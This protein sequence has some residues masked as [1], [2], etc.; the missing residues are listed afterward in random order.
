MYFVYFVDIYFPIFLLYRDC[1]TEDEEDDL[2]FESLSLPLQTTSSSSKE[3]K[4]KEKELDLIRDEK[5]SAKEEIKEKKQK[6]VEN[7]FVNLDD[8]RQLAKKIRKERNRR[9]KAIIQNPLSSSSSSSSSS[10]SLCE[11]HSSD[12]ESSEENEEGSP[13]VHILEISLRNC[14]GLRALHDYL[15]IPYLRLKRDLLRS[16]LERVESDLKE[17]DKLLRTS[18]TSK[19]KNSYVTFVR[20]YESRMRYVF[21]HDN[22]KRDEF[23]FI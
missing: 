9:E 5:I 19:D 1:V 21:K 8:I 10:V 15:K 11:E 13:G 7:N 23:S 4:E 16:Q 22:C 12:E 2:K 3:S 14:Y 6:R 20:T 18:L 17:Q